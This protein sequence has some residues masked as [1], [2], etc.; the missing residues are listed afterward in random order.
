MLY[1]DVRYSGDATTAD[2]ASN[3]GA[4]HLEP[5]LLLV[6]NVVE[7]GGLDA[8]GIARYGR[9]STIVRWALEDP[10]DERERRRNEVIAQPDMQ[11]NRNPF[12]DDEGLICRLYPVGW[13]RLPL[14]LPSVVRP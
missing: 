11:G 14:Y 4:C 5:D 1:M 12:I 8:E 3:G 7:R 2:V 10:V 6:E 9:L 13:C